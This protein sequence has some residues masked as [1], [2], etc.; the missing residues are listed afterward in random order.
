MAA[1]SAV[2]FDGK[3]Y[4][5]DL[6]VNERF[7]LYFA[8]M[9]QRLAAWPLRRL[10]ARSLGWLPDFADGPAPG[11]AAPAILATGG[12]LAMIA[13]HH[14]LISGHLYRAASGAGCWPLAGIS[15]PDYYHGCRAP[16]RVAA[17][18][19]SAAPISSF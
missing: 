16:P 6:I 8:E 14:A 2:G 11:G 1:Y 7:R 4:S 17:I 5:A 15:R 10:G 19:D 18:A 9:G 12:W 13:D 3:T